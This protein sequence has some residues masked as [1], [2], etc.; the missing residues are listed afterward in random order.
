MLL[1]PLTIVIQLLIFLLGVL[2]VGVELPLMD[3]LRISFRTDATVRLGELPPPYPKIMWLPPERKDR[4]VFVGLRLGWKEVSHDGYEI[5]SL[6][7]EYPPD[8]LIHYYKKALC[9]KGWNR[10]SSLNGPKVISYTYGFKGLTPD[11]DRYIRF[12]YFLPGWSE[13]SGY[14]AFVAHN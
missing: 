8:D 5:R 6:E 14:Q 12:G 2:S 7:L 10:I 13:S 4:M 1:I 3:C 9:T 11:E